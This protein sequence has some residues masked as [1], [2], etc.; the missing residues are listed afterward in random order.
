MPAPHH[1]V[2]YRPGGLS[3][4]KLTVSKRWRHYDC[5]EDKRETVLFAFVVLGLVSLVLRQE[6]CWEERLQKWPILCRVGRKTL[7]ESI[8]L[9]FV[10]LFCFIS[11]VNQIIVLIFLCEPL[12]MSGHC[13]NSFTLQVDTREQCTFIT[14]LLSDRC[15]AIAAV[16]GL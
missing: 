15:S 3:D 9:D 13:R 16:C 11:V 12:V 6:I 1:S 14:W 7:T 2:F 4:A 5:L 10:V 8:K